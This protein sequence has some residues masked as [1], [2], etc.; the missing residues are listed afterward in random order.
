VR[1]DDRVRVL[2]AHVD[3]TVALYERMFVVVGEGPDAEV[4]DVWPVDLRGW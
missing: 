3:P 4:T 2:P 1:V